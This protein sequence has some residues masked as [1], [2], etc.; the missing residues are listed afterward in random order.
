MT[1]LFRRLMICLL[2][3]TLVLAYAGAESTEL[4][5]PE[6]DETQQ[7]TATDDTPSIDDVEEAGFTLYVYIENRRGLME[8]GKAGLSAAADA[9]SAVYAL[10]EAEDR[11]VILAMPD[12]EKHTSAVQVLTAVRCES[13]PEAVGDGIM[14]L[15]VNRI[16]DRSRTAGLRD[17]AAQILA[18]GGDK[19]LVFFTSL[20]N[21][22]DQ[23]DAFRAQLEQLNCPVVFAQLCASERMHSLPGNVNAVYSAAADEEALPALLDAL[24]PL[25]EK[26]RQ[27]TAWT[28]CIPDE[29]GKIDFPLGYE[30]HVL[31]HISRAP[32]PREDAACNGRRL[33]LFVL[34]GEQAADFA[35]LDLKPDSRLLLAPGK[36]P[37]AMEST[38]ALNETAAKGQPQ[39]IS[40]TITPYRADMNWQVALV[41]TNSAGEAEQFAMT[42]DRERYTA[43][44]APKD[45]GTYTVQI[46]AVSGDGGI[47][48]CNDL[49]AVRVENQPPAAN[50]PPRDPL[51]LYVGSPVEIEHEP[52]LLSQFF[53]DDEPETLVYALEST[54]PG[55]S[56]EGDVLSIDSKQ[57]QGIPNG[58]LVFLAHDEGEEYARFAL[59]VKT[60]DVQELLRGAEAS[61]KL[62][63]SDLAKGDSADFTLTF[64]LPKAAADYCSAL[65][66]GSVQTLIDAQAAL[67]SAFE[68]MPCAIS[69]AEY[70]EKN[71]TLTWQSTTESLQTSGEYRLHASLA[72]YNADGRS[73]PPVTVSALCRVVNRAPELLRQPDSFRLI[74]P[75]FFETDI[76][77]HETESYDLSAL[78]AG[79][80]QETL[81]FTLVTP[82]F[83]MAQT[84]DGVL[85][86]EK[87]DAAAGQSFAWDVHT[88]APKITI[89]LDKPVNQSRI[90]FDVRDQEDA[91]MAEQLVFSGSVSTADHEER[92]QV[93]LIV[94]IA[95]ATFVAAATALIIFRC[96]TKPTFKFC[97]LSV[98]L[99]DG[100]ARCMSLSPWRTKRITLWEIVLYMGLPLAELCSPELLSKACISPVRRKRYAVSL[101]DKQE[102]WLEES[103]GKA[104]RRPLG[105]PVTLYLSSSVHNAVKLTVNVIAESASTRVQE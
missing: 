69:A 66:E 94:S 31:L 16:D 59:P 1:K 29:D 20:S 100:A 41:L 101:P 61:L 27:I 54:V 84:E 37:F 40:C 42:G 8:N 39:K 5:P 58:E 85:L 21:G 71:R 35:P 60:V 76:Q 4:P 80:T 88:A 11:V 9:I 22:V 28:P 14:A 89:C 93:I 65:P 83:A 78:V 23:P 52:I 95:A 82:G 44:I 17:V 72:W 81:T 48:L 79:E 56:V 2:A 15:D 19:A 50:K 38:S 63:S 33:Q 70:D 57:L 74:L 86:T 104:L 49:G 73:Q 45:G 55:V 77:P 99:N 97:R 10:M 64:T 47:T 34:S 13:M 7:Q 98:Q 91:V 67:E 26:G 68:H 87:A 6:A 96:A 43:Q 30:D 105:T 62:N 92:K 3:A 103:S 53:R 12:N 25:V 36:H 90:A 46:Q 51:V 32:T 18:D 102:C 75:G 24:L